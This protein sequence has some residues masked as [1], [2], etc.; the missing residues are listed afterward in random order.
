MK[1]TDAFEPGNSTYFMTSVTLMLTGTNWLMG[2]LK[3]YVFGL[4]KEN[5]LRSVLWRRPLIV[6]GGRSSARKGLLI[7]IA[8]DNN[9][10][11]SALQNIRST[12]NQI[13]KIKNNL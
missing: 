6:V 10:I 13:K 4:R 9:A 3:M 12:E 1:V 8:H 5:T 7:F 11:Q 2:T